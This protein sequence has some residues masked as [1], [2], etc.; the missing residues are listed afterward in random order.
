MKP[1]IIRKVTKVGQ[2]GCPKIAVDRKNDIK[3]ERVRARYWRPCESETCWFDGIIYATSEYAKI[4]SSRVK[5]FYS[6]GSLVRVPQDYHFEC[7]PP[8]T[9][10]L[11]RFFGR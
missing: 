7:V 6:K 1:K 10:P 9:R 4:T 2:D 8:Y 3:M 5:S 11:L